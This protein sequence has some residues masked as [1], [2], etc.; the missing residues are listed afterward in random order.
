MLAMDAFSKNLYKYA[1]FLSS[2]TVSGASKSVPA[3]EAA[4]GSAW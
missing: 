2:L 3:N 4:D 1:G